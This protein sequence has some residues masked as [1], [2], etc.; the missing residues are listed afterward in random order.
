[1]A[2]NSDNF[3]LSNWKITLPVSSSGSNSG[4]A[5][6]ITS[7][8]HYESIYFYDAPDKAMVFKA[9]VDGATTSGSKYARSELREMNG[10]DRAAWTLK[11]G[12]VMSA[13]LKIDHMP[14]ASN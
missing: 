8:S 1:M 6:E 2:Y 12:G 7:L 13:T 14:S 10:S 4:T 5:T 11:Q 9:H 3:D